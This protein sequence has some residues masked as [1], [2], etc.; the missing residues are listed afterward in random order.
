MI[1]LA[2]LG[3]GLLAWV[4]PGEIALEQ[5]A[6]RL[7]PASALR[8]RAALDDGGPDGPRPAWLE[9]HPEYGIR[10]GDGRGGSWLVREGWT[11]AGAPLPAPFWVEPLEVLALGG[12]PGVERYLRRHAIDAQR[13]ELAR[14]GEFDCFVVGGR[15]APAQFWLEKDDFFVR[16]VRLAGGTRVD[17]GAP[18]D[19][20]GAPG[21]SFPGRIE[22]SG[23]FGRAATLVVE[24]VLPAPDLDAAD[25]E[26]ALWNFRDLPDGSPGAAGEDPPGPEG[27][28][29][30][31]MEEEAR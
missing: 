19:W 18:R 21:A 27:G 12:G 6:E 30:E 15:D 3:A 9:V 1:R 26:P 25:F 14:C 17:L 13:N 11:L 23:A 5:L 10:A 2:L 31:R 4:L 28:V 29:P 24:S 20:E 22:V 16:G 7:E 8:V